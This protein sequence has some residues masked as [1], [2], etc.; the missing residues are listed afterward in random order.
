MKTIISIG[1]TVFLL[2][3]VLTG[4]KKD[5]PVT[6]PEEQNPQELITTL[7]LSLVD[8]AD[9]APDAI[10][11]FRDLDGPGGNPPTIDTLKVQVG[12]VYEGTILLLDQSKTPADTISHEVEEEGT[13]HRVWFTVG[14]GASGK[15]IVSYLD[16]DGGSPPMPI[17]LKIEVAVS[18]GGAS[19]GTLRTVLKHYDT[20]SLKR[21]DTNGTLGETDVDV[22]FS[23]RIG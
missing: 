9:V 11:A 2:A 5:D 4:C 3:G 6:P 14:G 19:T 20:E 18:V 12:V 22:T 21:S 8:T 16:A 7:V 10:A 1:L 23:V 17:G 13:L 15:M